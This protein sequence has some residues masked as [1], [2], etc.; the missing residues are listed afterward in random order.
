MSDTKEDLEEAV[1]MV[2]KAG[3]STGHADTCAGLL[4]EVLGEIKSRQKLLMDCRDNHC[5]LMKERDSLKEQLALCMRYKTAA[6]D[7][8][9]TLDELDVYKQWVHDLNAQMVRAAKES[10]T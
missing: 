8:E 5:I 9:A 1:T 6:E 2:L 4:G 10:N 3:L 7:L